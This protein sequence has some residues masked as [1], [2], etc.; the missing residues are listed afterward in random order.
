MQS[1]SS[2]AGSLPCIRCRGAG[3]LKL[4][5]P[6]RDNDCCESIADDVER[7]SSQ[8]EVLEAL[9][10]TRHSVLSVAARALGSAKFHAVEGCDRIVATRG[11]DL[12][13]RGAGIDLHGGEALTKKDPQQPVT[14]LLDWDPKHKTLLWYVIYGKTQSE[15]KGI[16]VINAATGAFVR[17]G[18]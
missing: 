13:Q 4:A 12:D 11:F 6:P 7:C 17:A 15:A 18:K 16:G 1:G 2:A 9:S 14:Y 8:A 3:R 10:A 5:L